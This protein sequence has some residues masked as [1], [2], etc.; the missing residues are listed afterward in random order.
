MSEALDAADTFAD[1][2]KLVVPRDELYAAN[3]LS[4]NGTVVV[5]SGFPRVRELIESQGYPTRS[6]AM[7]EFRKAGGS[8]T[9]LSVLL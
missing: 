7:T 6:L 8:L 2:E 3:C 4:V 5:S 9:C 1:K